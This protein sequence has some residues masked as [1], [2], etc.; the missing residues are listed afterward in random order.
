MAGVYG[1]IDL[2]NHPWQTENDLI[3]FVPGL[4]SSLDIQ[5]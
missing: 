2:H 3:A 1:A 4:N 5:T